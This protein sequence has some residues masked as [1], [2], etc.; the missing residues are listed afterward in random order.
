MRKQLNIGNALPASAT[1]V[2]GQAHPHVGCKDHLSSAS[3][4]LALCQGF[5]AFSSPELD[6]LLHSVT[7]KCLH[8]FLTNQVCRDSYGLMTQVSDAKEKVFNVQADLIFQV[9]KKVQA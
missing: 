3:C 5:L 6:Q 1:V 2:F 8:G 4:C 9:S 7:C